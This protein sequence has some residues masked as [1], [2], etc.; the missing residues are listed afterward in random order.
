MNKKFV[1][2]MALILS[3]I[4]G[5]ILISNPNASAAIQ[6]DVNRG[7]NYKLIWRKPMKKHSVYIRKNVQKKSARYSK[8]LTLRY[9]FNNDHPNATWIVN[10]QE[11]LYNKKTHKY[12]IYYH[13]K[14][15]NGKS[16]GWIFKGY[17]TNGKNPYYKNNSNDLNKIKSLI[18]QLRSSSSD[19]DKNL[20]DLEVKIEKLQNEN[21]LLNNKI[22]SQTD[23]NKLDQWFKLQQQID[24][25]TDKY[26]KLE[27]SRIKFSVEVEIWMD[28]D[29]FISNNSRDKFKQK[30]NDEIS[31]YNNK[32]K[33][34]E[35][36]SQEY[37]IILKIQEYTEIIEVDNDILNIVN[38]NPDQWKN[39]LEQT[40]ENKVPTAK[41]QE[42][43]IS[44]EETVISDQIMNL[45]SQQ[46][47]ILQNLNL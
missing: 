10:A 16:E 22:S 11:K 41:N 31:I 36:N 4:F 38:D 6:R 29:E 12:N 28:I 34:L 3:F 20:N 25:L 13:V 47:E 19:Y 46:A 39:V 44:N 17:L 45:K 30:L 14:L 2:I 18:D 7:N 40:S 15:K 37:S 23:N 24:E 27:I 43:E 1:I 42:R 9:A 33:K 26:Q 35:N 8:H 21:Q 32:F 5:N